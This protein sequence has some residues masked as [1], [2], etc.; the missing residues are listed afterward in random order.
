MTETMIVPT[1]R[2]NRALAAHLDSVLRVNSLGARNAATNKDAYQRTADD[3]HD[4]LLF[5]PDHKWRF[6]GAEAWLDPLSQTP[7]LKLIGYPT[8]T[9][10]L[11]V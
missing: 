1:Q 7:I 9:Q 8:T 11:G 3:L 10:D 4:L 5:A 6:M 2:L